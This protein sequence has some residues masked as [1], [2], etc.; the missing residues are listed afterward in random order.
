MENNLRHSA[1]GSNDAYDVTNSLTGYEPNDTVSNELIDS[2]GPFSYVTPSSD[3][4]IDDTTL[5]KLLAEVHREYADCRSPEG[6]C[7][8]PS[9]M[10]VMVDRTVKPVEKSNIDQFSSGVRNTYSA[11]NQFPAIT[12][13]EKMVD[14]T[15]KPVGESSS[16]AQIRTLFDEQRQMIIAECCEKVSHH[17]LQAARAE[18]ER[19]ILQEELWRQQKDFREVHRQNLTEMEELRKFQSSTFDTPAR[20]KLIEDQNTIME[21]SGELQ[22]LQNEVNC[23]N[24]SKDFQD[25]ESVRSGN[26]HVTSQPMLFPTHPIPEGML[27]PSFVSPRRKEGPPDIWDTPGISA[28][29]FANSQA[30]S[31]APY[32]QE[33]NPPWKKTIEEPLHMSTAEKSDRPERNQDLRCQSGPSA[34]NSVIFSGGDSS[35]NYGTDQ[36]R[37]QSSDLHF[38][39]FPTPA[40]FACWKIRFKTEVCTCSQFPTE[41]M[42]WI[43]EVELVDSVDELRSSSSIRGIS[44][45]NFEVFDARI[46]SALNKII[47]N[48]QF[49]R[50]ISLEEQKAQKEDRFLRGRQIAY[51]I[52]DHFRVTGAHDSVENYTDLFTI[53]LRNDDIQEFDSKWDGILLS[54]TKIPHDD[55]L[56]GLYKLRIRASEKLKTALELYD[57]EIHQ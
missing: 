21:L 20:Q 28:N 26:S 8:S 57:L 54:M 17:E 34:K 43:K 7:V 30:S 45:P 25:A 50:R 12:Q 48:S 4:D 3:Q 32:P 52:Y 27:R 56:E 47:Q 37:L 31:T 18:Q 5:G 39:K 10:C 2:Q 11:H 51:L 33:L 36:Q 44:M 40:T 24:D 22:E 53:V 41:A 15:G 42:Q 13:A 23:M 49:K 14:T 35:K 6:V 1:K 38:D 55:I 29:V 46:A 9:S 16:S 19:Q